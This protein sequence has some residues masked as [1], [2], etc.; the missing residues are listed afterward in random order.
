MARKRL[1]NDSKNSREW[2]GLAFGNRVARADDHVVIKATDASASSIRM[3]TGH[4]PSK[5]RQIFG[6]PI[7]DTKSGKPYI[8]FTAKYRL[9]KTIRID[10]S[11]VQN[12][13]CRKSQLY[14]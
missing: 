6:D 11:Q 10:N 13:V 12:V 5:N 14:K 3:S 8:G 4:S 7:R 9:D 2:L 1:E